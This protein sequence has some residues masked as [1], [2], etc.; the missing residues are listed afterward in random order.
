[1]KRILHTS[2]VL[3]IVGLLIIVL[4]FYFAQTKT[5]TLQMFGFSDFEITEKTEN[6]IGSV[7][8][9]RFTANNRTVILKA[10]HAKDVDIA[11]ATQYID[12]KRFGIESLYQSTPSP[13]PDVITRTI[14]CPDEFKPIFYRSEQDN[15]DSLYY[16]LYAND[17]F[18]YGACSDDLIRYRAIFYLVYCKEKNEI[19]Q[20]ELF[21]APEEFTHDLA[22]LLKSFNC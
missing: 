12:E 5:D 7:H 15:Q 19:Y 10:E 1:M 22:S 3:L 14:E 17:R 21:T 11:K 18:T 20:I 16:I 8:Y 13:Y 2:R 9:T 4:V 6:N